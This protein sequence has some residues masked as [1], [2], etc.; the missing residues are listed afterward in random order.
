[1]KYPGENH[2]CLTA[3]QVRTLENARRSERRFAIKE[4]IA[5][6]LVVTFI[7]GLL[8]FGIVTAVLL[9]IT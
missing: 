2:N 5:D 6:W 1:M 4:R 9:A 3:G 8:V 7:V